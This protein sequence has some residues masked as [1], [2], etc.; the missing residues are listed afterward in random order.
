MPK[1]TNAESIPLY[2]IIGSAGTGNRSTCGD[3][4]GAFGCARVAR[5]P[6]EVTHANEGVL[7]VTKADI[8]RLTHLSS[9]AG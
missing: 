5:R 9:C 8:L 3:S 1:T 6:I 7:R 4:R 2:I